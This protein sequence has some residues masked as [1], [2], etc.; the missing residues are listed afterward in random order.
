MS[1]I[2]F[3]SNFGI[4]L[5]YPSRSKPEFSLQ[6]ALRSCKSTDH[7]SARLVIA[8]NNR[9]ALTIT[10]RLNITVAECLPLQIPRRRPVVPVIDGIYAA[11]RSLT[12]L[13]FHDVRDKSGCPRDHEYAVVRRRRH[14]Q[15]G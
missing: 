3:G 7:G 1:T 8:I 10:E 15:V 6:F 14:P 5:G 11:H 9:N 12:S 2:F 4:W 13:F